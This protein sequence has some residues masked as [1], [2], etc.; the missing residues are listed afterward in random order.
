M[1][2][3]A[4]IPVSYTHLDVYKRQVL[5]DGVNVGHMTTNLGGK[6]SF[7]VELE[8]AEDVAVEIVK[9]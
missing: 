7:S 4:V 9:A 8:K 2:A 5:L 1:P 6:L 3:A